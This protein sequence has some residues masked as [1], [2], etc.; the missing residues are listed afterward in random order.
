M[1]AIRLMPKTSGVQVDYTLGPDPASPTPIY[2]LGLLGRPA[3]ATAQRSDR[4]RRAL[5]Q[6]LR[7]VIGPSQGRA[8][9]AA[10]LAP[11]KRPAALG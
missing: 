5:A 2:R 3:S 9:P 7:R 6:L 4:T 11:R 8:A 10:A 1:P